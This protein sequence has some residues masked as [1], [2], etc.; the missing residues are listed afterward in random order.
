[1]PPSTH[2]HGYYIYLLEAMK[3]ARAIFACRESNAVP[4][5]PGIGSAKVILATVTNAEAMSATLGGLG[6]NVKGN[7]SVKASQPDLTAVLNVIKRAA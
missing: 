7:Y 5:H 1:M 3:V 6:I 2:R 4:A